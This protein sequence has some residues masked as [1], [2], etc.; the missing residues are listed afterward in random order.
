MKKYLEQV[1]RYRWLVIAMTLL[2]TGLAIHQARNLRIIIDPNTMLPHN[3]P[4]IDTSN[5]VEK[6]FGSKDIAIIG[7]TPKTGDV[8][9]PEVLRKVQK[10]TAA[11]MQ[12]P[13]VIKENLLSLT[14]R[15]AK[16]IIGTAEGME[17]R[18]LI[19]T[20]PETPQ[21]MAALR[22]AIKNNPAY[23]NSIISQDE[24]TAVIVV[25]FKNGKGGF[26]G[27]MDTANKA[28]DNVRDDTVDI[29]IGGLPSFLSRI[30]IYSERMGILLPLAILLVG[31]ILFEAFRS[32]QGM[33]LPL[34]T[35]ILAVAWGVGT[36]GAV[37][38]P[39][40]VF[41]ATTPI[42]IL[43][44]AAG[45]AVQLLKRYYEEYYR[46]ID[47][48]GTTI[49]PR[50]ANRLAVI[51]SLSKAGPV[52]MVAGMV[53]ALGFFSLMVFE[54]TTVRT[55]GIFTGMGILAAL[56]LE[57]TFI[58]AIRSMLKP[59]GEK[60][61]LLEK[62]V[63]IW[64]IIVSKI[65]NQVTNHRQ[66]VYGVAAG[67]I[68]IGLFGMNMVVTNNSTKSYFAKDASFM[69]EDRFLNAHIGGTN[70]LSLLIE[71]KNDDAI[72]NPKVL[73]AMD[74]IQ[75]FLDQQQYVGK[76]LSMADFIK[77]MNQAMH[78]DDPAFY[79]IP[80][81]GNLIS[82]YLLLYSM[83]GEPGDF[84]TYVDYDYRMANM[85]AFL[86][87]DSSAHIET[88]VPKIRAFAAER[89]GDRATL[90]IG[91]SVPQGTALNEVMVHGKILNIVQIAAVVFMISS[92]V[93]RSLL[94]GLL[95][96]L[97]LLMAVI[98]NFAMMGYSG[99]YLNISNSLSSAMA[100]GIGADYAIYLIYRLREDIRKG[101]NEM[102]AVRH[103]L[104]TAGKA[105]LFV[106]IAISVGYG[107]LF[108]SVGFNIHIWLATLIATSMLTSVFA[109]LFLIPSVI[110]TFRPDFVYRSSSAIKGATA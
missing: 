40:D 19:T 53:A 89:L 61:G 28:L 62:R 88:L 50:E 95:V 18:P 74:E 70:T 42:L 24:R 35:A 36:M 83:S 73:Q 51:E 80:E 27:M 48:S 96:L 67:L 7:I 29:A 108:F 8:F 47:I 104:R 37:G 54:I 81:D 100:I 22:Q 71:G 87:V 1:I 46:I 77:R 16:N 75:Q 43:A 86:K 2:L 69:Q 14:A 23:I 30:E 38:V 107:V 32:F 101:E 56:T 26:R 84:D 13:G 15:R 79:K 12:S 63:R 92:L 10:V 33:I 103:V 109:A 68:V 9:Q 106:A 85:T 91:G 3:H 66:R 6:L 25:S 82:Q 90:H 76:T 11:L 41:N 57:M 4:Y 97:P 55:F 17:V 20:I 105:C 94:A 34:I 39:M 64:D 65:A 98:A 93:F 59:P 44:V 52:M 45:H 78:G 72:K 99:M 49:T 102:E 110:L 31:L 60:D 58:P 21:Q 5:R